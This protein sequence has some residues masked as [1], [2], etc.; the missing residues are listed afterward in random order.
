MGSEA[1]PNPGPAPRGRVPGV[2][3]ARLWKL[4][5][6]IPKRRVRV[7]KPQG[8]EKARGRR[9]PAPGSTDRERIPIPSSL[10][11]RFETGS[12]RILSVLPGETVTVAEP[13]MI[14]LADL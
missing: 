4:G 9:R 6:G 11:K 3:A 5:R 2:R 10:S 7:V 8:Q 12:A 13:H 14:E 1:G